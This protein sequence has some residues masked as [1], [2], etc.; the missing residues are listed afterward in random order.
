MSY[1]LQNQ[2]LDPWRW[3]IIQFDQDCAHVWKVDEQN[4]TPC[5]MISLSLVSFKWGMGYLKKDGMPKKDDP[6]PPKKVGAH[7]GPSVKK[8]LDTWRF[9]KKKYIS[10]AMSSCYPNKGE[11]ER[12]IKGVLHFHHPFSTHVHNL[13]QLVWFVISMDPLFD[14]AIYVT[15]VHASTSLT[16]SSTYAILRS[17][18]I[19]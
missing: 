16:M 15:Q 3:H 18:N 19:P 9:K 5:L 2:K 7:E 17:W 10:I 6:H 4:K 14:F 11:R 8:N 1:I 13:D 12:F